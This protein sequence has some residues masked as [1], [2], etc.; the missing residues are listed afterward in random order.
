MPK[1][2]ELSSRYASQERTL[3]DLLAQWRVP[4]PGERPQPYRSPDIGRQ[5]FGSAL[6]D[7][8]APDYGAN[9]HDFLKYG[10]NLF[11]GFGQ[12][13]VEGV[14]QLEGPVEAW[15]LSPYE[16]DPTEDQL[17]ADAAWDKLSEADR[18]GIAIR[19]TMFD[20]LQGAIGFA[21]QTPDQIL[22]PEKYEG[23]DVPTGISGIPE[24]LADAAG[25]IL[26][27]P[28]QMH[29]LAAETGAPEFVE[30]GL[31]GISGII[32]ALRTVPTK[33]LF[34]T[35]GLPEAMK[36]HA[37][38]AQEK[39]QQAVN[40]LYESPST[41][42]FGSMMTKGVYKGA[43]KGVEVLDNLRKRRRAARTTPANT[44]GEVG[45]GPRAFPE[46][47]RRAATEAVER[48]RQETGAGPYSSQKIAQERAMG[49]RRALEE[50][51]IERLRQ[52]DAG[53]E[54]LTVKIPGETK[55]KKVAPEKVFGAPKKADTI[56]VSRAKKA[57]AA[58][59]AG[60]VVSGA[61]A[62]G[63]SDD[64]IEDAIGTG[65]SM[66]GVAG[67]VAVTK[68][69][70]VRARKVGEATMRRIK[71]LGDG[72]GMTINGLS[73]AEKMT[74][75]YLTTVAS[76]KLPLNKFRPELVQTFVDRYGKIIEKY[77][78]HIDFGLYKFEDGKHISIDMNVRMKTVRQAR[79]VASKL[80]QESVRVIRDGTYVGG[81]PAGGTGVL[82]KGLK[83]V[84]AIDRTI[85]TALNRDSA[86]LTSF[87]A[88]AIMDL[89]PSQRGSFTAWKKT[90]DRHFGEMFPEPD[91]RA[92]YESS[93]KEFSKLADEAIDGALPELQKVAKRIEEFKWASDWYRQAAPAIE[94][95]F[96]PEM[97]EKIAGIIALTSSG[98][99]FR[100]N[101]TK[102]FD[103]VRAIVKGK[104]LA[105][106]EKISG[107]AP[108]T[109]KKVAA[110]LREG[111]SAFK[112]DPKLYPFF[113]NLMN[114]TELDRALVTVD[115]Q[116]LR[117][118]GFPDASRGARKS[119][120][121]A[122]ARVRIADA[123]IR[124]IADRLK[125]DPSDVQAAWWVMGKIERASG[126]AAKA[127][128]GPGV[129]LEMVDRLRN[130]LTKDPKAFPLKDRL[131]MTAAFRYITDE[132]ATG[133][134]VRLD[135][136][137]P[138]ARAKGEAVSAGEVEYYTM[139][140]KA[141]RQ[142][143]VEPDIPQPPKALSL[144]TENATAEASVL[145]A[146]RSAVKTMIETDKL[147]DLIR[148]PEGLVKQFEGR[149]NAMEQRIYQRG[150]AGTVDQRHGIIRMFDAVDAKVVSSSKAGRALAQIGDI[151]KKYG[152]NVIIGGIS[153]GLLFYLGSDEH[154]SAQEKLA[155]GLKWLVGS[156]ALGAL[157][158]RGKGKK[159]LVEESRPKPK[160]DLADAMTER[161]RNQQV[162]VE[163]DGGYGLSKEAN[164][165]MRESVNLS[166]IPDANK[167]SWKH[168]YGEM[169][170]TGAPEEG[171]NLAREAVTLKRPMSDLEVAAMAA[172]RDQTLKQH[173]QVTMEMEKLIDSSDPQG[174]LS[175]LRQ[176][177][178][179]LLE[180]LDVLSQGMVASGR[181]SARALAIRRAF[182]AE[183]SFEVADLLRE[184]K[185]RKGSKLSEAE[186][187]K[188]RESA[189]QIAELERK[190]ADAERNMEQSIKDR[191]RA[192]A[193]AVAEIEAKRAR[194]Q[195][196]TATQKQKIRAER[197]EIKK[198]LADL[199]LRVNDITGVSTEG[200]YLIG[201][202]A[203]TYMKE[204]A[205][206]LEQVVAQV[207]QVIPQLTDADVYEA[208][209]T[210]NPKAQR[211]ARTA[212]EKRVTLLKKQARLL[213]EV[214]KLE[215]GLAPKQGERP[216][217]LTN[218]TI[219]ELQ[220]KV[221]QLRKMA[222]RGAADAKRLER[223]FETMN[224]LQDQ[225]TN[226]YRDIKKNRPI[227]PVE[228]ATTKQMVRDLRSH[229][230][231]IDQ[232]ADLNEQLRT[233][234]FKTPTG[235]PERRLPPEMEK[236]RVELEVARKKVRLELA[237]MEPLTMR[238]RLNEGLNT[239]RTLK[240]TADFSSVLRQGLIATVN[241]PSKAV[242]AFLKSAK[243]AF[244]EMTAEQIQLGIKNAPHHWIRERSK[245]YLAELEGA[246]L[247]A[248]EEMFMSR[249]LRKAPVFKKIV[250]ASERQFVTYLN[251]M[252]VAAFDEFLLKNPNATPVELAAWADYINV[253]TGRG[254]LRSF[255]TAGTALATVVFAPRFAVS[256]FETPYTLIRHWK[257]P[258]V[259]ARIAKELAT[260]MSVGVTALA[261][262]DL[263]G[264]E[265][266]LDPREADFGKI[267]FGDTRIDIWGGMQQPARLFLRAVLQAGKAAGINEVGAS[268]S[269]ESVDDLMWRF[270]RYK[271]SPGVNIVSSLLEGKNAV[272]EEVTPI[273]VAWKSIL[274]L[275]IEDIV[276][277]Y[278]QSGLEAATISG[279]LNFMGV[280]TNTYPDSESA[281]RRQIEKLRS[282]GQWLEAAEANKKLLEVR[283]QKK[284]EK[285]AKEAEKR[286]KQNNVGGR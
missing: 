206:T 228:I 240:A 200:A 178:R 60:A 254:N 69:K 282:E 94:R 260:T 71:T 272:G 93:Q 198:K 215:E 9:P 285:R 31:S 38:Q 72:D 247:T 76:V 2:D 180:D 87:G 82:P 244:S 83:S 185:V 119:P 131:E 155:G 7:M 157:F 115:M 149:P 117:D 37:G 91:W 133:R 139:D 29:F 232:L 264:L 167:R 110:F 67:A 158:G 100:S 4:Q 168:L 239:L 95:W 181:E 176:R 16:E 173:R 42:V 112:D 18:I 120:T 230:K 284:A 172:K 85:R 275:I 224:R 243:A 35:S 279:A 252:R 270:I 234:D 205:A 211:R 140:K 61:I 213:D 186:T 169:V 46:T 48:M 147:Y 49:A 141:H 136:S 130:F 210:K 23:Q 45:S 107:Y 271:A 199:G 32:N 208:I 47:A 161:Y 62:L 250:G 207:R 21:T 223:S 237:E 278:L 137:N 235:R 203:V 111:A 146:T 44:F 118:M 154:S 88:A 78:D 190:L 90:M 183:E 124:L 99:E 134:K 277:S 52:G 121:P 187:M 197:A 92:L 40:H 113:R 142:N 214:R 66:A 22:N 164:Q 194:S 195:A 10:A 217:P 159:P 74:D 273:E 257:Q 219:T 156:M 50:A 216:K 102:T 43:A 135:P 281:L 170:R 256:R 286:A 114:Q 132:L 41:I 96:G 25:M 280:G 220:A 101:L 259:R 19:R 193:E 221:R 231:A 177:E 39:Y 153:G 242:P 202:L 84:S 138:K 58:L 162:R 128:R 5:L 227:D 98:M 15:P 222:Y 144:Y 68:G 261:L 191:D 145:S 36:I 269:G 212:A 14:S 245:L 192:V 20:A 236:V 108:G 233:G 106:I 248:R 6:D 126:I 127:G 34:A 268:Y 274:P 77:G 263:A 246:R 89:K 24:M 81:I 226:H 204:G 262:A 54:N 163:K 209:A 30:K 59:G 276:D 255:S 12:Q 152:G 97:V 182:L 105:E 174:K 151:V 143:K 225:L 33:A 55:M 28:S 265:V 26:D 188:V 51:S 64:K 258:R 179:L 201:Q 70:P 253:S 160:V 266:G 63:M 109:G 53:Y 148:D 116:A 171:I 249:L 56:G 73:L 80:N 11:S 251:M 238:G 8:E 229:M 125:M 129:P 103:Y 79:E 3:D 122:P 184:A 283:R 165:Q 218:Q 241:Y 17:R 196:K 267:R 150:Y 65:L 27:V 13:A 1:L 166:R 175:V 86:G 57:L 123:A 104:S 75:G 189:K